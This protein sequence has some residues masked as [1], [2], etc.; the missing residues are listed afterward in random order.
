MLEEKIK[1]W[2]KTKDI[3]LAHEICEELVEFAKEEDNYVDAED[4]IS[5]VAFWGRDRKL[6]DPK[7]QLNK[8]I[9]EVGE[10]AHEICRNRYESGMLSDAIGDT[11]VTVIVLADIL[12]YDPIDCLEEAYNTIK[13]RK[14]TTENGTFVKEQ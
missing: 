4:L 3:T 2:S 11:L 12:G 1:Q 7:A 8:V 6:D 10:M 5:S 14:G 13:E 9:E